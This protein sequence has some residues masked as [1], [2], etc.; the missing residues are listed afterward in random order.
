MFGELL[1]SSFG[2]KETAARWILQ[3]SSRGHITNEWQSW[4]SNLGVYE[5]K[6]L[7]GPFHQELSVQCSSKP[8]VHTNYLVKM[9][10]LMKPEV[11]DDPAAL[12]SSQ[13]MLL[14]LLVYTLNSKD[15]DS[16]Y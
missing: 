13:V 4:D 1:R 5:V 3:V 11:P 15:I 9:Q 12:T 8:N 6:L 2:V 16:K 14:I 10:I 7:L